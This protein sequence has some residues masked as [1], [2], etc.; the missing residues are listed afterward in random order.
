MKKINLWIDDE[1]LEKL[2]L[3]SLS[4]GAGISENIRRAIDQAWTHR[5]PTPSALSDG[6]HAAKIKFSKR[7]KRS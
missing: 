5:R 7:Q 1:R 3:L 6:R 4:N 2:R